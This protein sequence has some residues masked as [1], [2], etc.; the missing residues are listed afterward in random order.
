MDLE[1]YLLH[2]FGAKMSRRDALRLAA[3]VAGGLAALKSSGLHAEPAAPPS[4]RRDPELR[5]PTDEIFDVAAVEAGA[6]EP[7]PYGPGDQRGTFNEVTPQ[8]T[9][10][11]LRILSRGEPVITYNLGERMFNGFPAFPVKVPRVYE[12][13]LMLLGYEPP[14]GFEGILEGPEPLGPNRLS[15]HEERFLQNFTHQIGTQIDSLN[16]TGVGGTFY[17]GFRGPDIAR[18]D[19]TAALG[20]EHAG[21]IITRGIV[22]DILGLKVSQ[23]ATNDYFTTSGGERVLRDNYRITVGD[24]EAAMHREGLREITPGDVVLLRTGWTHLIRTDPER[25]L[26]QEPGIYLR[27]ARFLGAHRPAIIGSDTWGLEVVDPAVTQDFVFPCHQELITHRGIRIGEGIVTEELVRDGVFE[28]VFIV[29]PQNAPG[30]TA[31]NSPPAA[32][33]QPRRAGRHPA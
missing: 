1:Y 3:G 27:E 15:V 14:A 7:S 8:K 33:G 17:N 31:G 24:I 26:A 22:F 32:L 6:W 23:G 25:Y 20:I 16:H 29:T 2:R 12:Q 9:A 21:P 10:E 13:R 28:F 4:R 19:G 11:A 5:D 18:T 30:A